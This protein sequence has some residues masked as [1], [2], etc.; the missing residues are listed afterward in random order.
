[1]RV[2]L[3]F[4]RDRDRRRRT[5]LTLPLAPADGVL[6]VANGAGVP[7]RPGAH[8]KVDAEWMLVVDRTGDRVAVRRGQRGTQPALHAAGAMVHWGAPQVREVPVAMYREDW[9]L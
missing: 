2:E 5:R 1:V 8:V 3:E 7:A 9:D 6:V 4:E